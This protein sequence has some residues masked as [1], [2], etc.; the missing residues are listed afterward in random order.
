MDPLELGIGTLSLT[1]TQYENIQS[2]QASTVAPALARE[3]LGDPGR[4][5]KNRVEAL[6][7]FFCSFLSSFICLDRKPCKTNPMEI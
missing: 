7:G 4:S 5:N 3:A 2:L 1:L 6:K